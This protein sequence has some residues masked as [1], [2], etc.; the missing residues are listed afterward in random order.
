MTR[1][2]RRGAAG[3]RARGGTRARC[4]PTSWKTCSP[5]SRRA[6]ALGSRAPR[7][8]GGAEAGAA[9]GGGAGGAAAAQQVRV[10][11]PA[12][13]PRNDA[14]GPHPA[15]KPPPAPAPRPPDPVPPRLLSLP[16]LLSLARADARAPAQ[17]LPNVV[18]V[19]VGREAH[20]TVCGDT[21]GQFYDLLHIFKAP[22]A[23]P[24]PQRSLHEAPSK[25]PRRPLDAR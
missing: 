2:L 3:R 13:E 22:P 9:P 1:V 16:T 23:P 24:L 19:E 17:A 4:R 20:I 11:D 15:P 5:R 8:P 21:H 14:G 10:Q 12:T 6:P 7:P 18:P 25:P